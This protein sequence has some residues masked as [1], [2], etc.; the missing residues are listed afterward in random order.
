MFTV[1]I[2]DLGPWTKALRLTAE[3]AITARSPA[4]ALLVDVDGFYTQVNSFNSM[5]IGGAPRVV[6][7][8]GGSGMTSVFGF[9]QVRGR[10]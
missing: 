2:K 4:S 8:A 7:V 6:I 1:Y 9:I 10:A 3:G 5:M